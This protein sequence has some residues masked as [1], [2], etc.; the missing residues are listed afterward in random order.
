MTGHVFGRLLRDAPGQPP[1]RTWRV[2]VAGSFHR[3]AGA[4]RLVEGYLGVS[5]VRRRGRS[6]R[7]AAA[8]IDTAVSVV[9]SLVAA[10]VA[11]G[12]VR[13]LLHRR[14]PAVGD[15]GLA[16]QLGVLAGRRTRRVAAVVVD[17]DAAVRTRMAFIDA[18]IEGLTPDHVEALLTL[19]P[20]DGQLVGLRSGYPAWSGILP[21]VSGERRIPTSLAL[22]VPLWGSGWRAETLINVAVAKAGLPWRHV[23][24]EGVTNLAKG[25]IVNHP[26]A[27]ADEFARVIDI[28][29]MY[30]PE[31][32][33]YMR[34]PN[35]RAVGTTPPPS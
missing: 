24:F 29:I 11:F 2:P 34:H 5:L 3:D 31:L 25:K 1:L 13:A 20:H 8:V 22:S 28:W 17:L 27:W 15:R 14:G 19:P 10:V 9:G 21:S 6:D 32:V 4:P 33:T 30:L 16:A 12:L 18:D 35:G 23:K 7:V 26:Y